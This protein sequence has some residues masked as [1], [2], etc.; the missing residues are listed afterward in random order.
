MGNMKKCTNT[1]I[2]PEA[3]KYTTADDGPGPA[4]YGIKSTVGKKNRLPIIPDEPAYTAYPRL[5]YSDE[6]ESP[7]PVYNLQHLTCRGRADGP[8]FSMGTKKVE[9]FETDSPGPA[10]YMLK[11][12][13]G[14][15]LKILLPLKNIDPV[16]YPV[17]PFVFF[18]N[19]TISAL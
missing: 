3:F 18:F 4:A 19:F 11:S 16:S 6:T 17:S 9:N 13:R 10:A 12:D 2:V 14:P 8:K 1:K 5:R 7:G 15:K